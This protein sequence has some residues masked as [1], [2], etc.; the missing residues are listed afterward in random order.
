MNG[1]LLELYRHKTWATLRVIEH[2]QKLS[3]EHLDASTPG[4]FGTI[5]ETLRHLV[6]AEEG[7]FSI[8]TRKHLSEPL[9]DGVVKLEDL[10]AG[11]VPLDELAERI[12]R[13]GPRWEALAQDTDLAAREVTTQ[14][15][16]RMP[17]SVPMAQAI[18]HADDH[19][20]HVLSILGALGLEVPDLAVWD[21]AE[22]TG[23]MHELHATSAD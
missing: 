16:W 17:G 21:H 19:R 15:G 23:L 4:T 14:D 18:H 22:A 12:R 3:D 20:S 11:V 6:G 1:A 13:L 9:P 5:R 8:L 2:C 7:Y 10:P